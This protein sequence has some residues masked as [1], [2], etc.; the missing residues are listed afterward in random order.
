M[1]LERLDKLRVGILVAKSELDRA[2][3][4]L[5]EQQAKKAE[6]QV[7]RAHIQEA[8]LLCNLCMDKQSEVKKFIEKMVTAFVQACFGPNCYYVL[9]PVVKN[10]TIVGLKEFIVEDGIAR[11]PEN[12]YGGMQNIIAMAFRFC[13]IILT[14]GITPVCFCDEPMT[15]S[16]ATLW[17]LM[18]SIVR[19]I[20]EIRP[21]FQFVAITH[22]DADF[23]HIVRVS[24]PSKVSKVTEEYSVSIE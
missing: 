22:V 14:K 11:E 17:N 12:T 15:G 16:N 1:N 4:A 20:Q 3:Q 18:L 8:I 19:K 6:L 23:N 7:K 5:V 13:I 9:E 10:D 2:E 21:D 24:K